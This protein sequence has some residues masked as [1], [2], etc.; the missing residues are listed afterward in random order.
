MQHLVALDG[1]GG[2]HFVE[3]LGGIWD[4]GDAAFVVDPRLPLVA[5]AELFAAIRPTHALDADGSMTSVPD[6]D[7]VEPGDALVIATSGTSGTPK[8]TVLTHAALAAS[9]AATSKRLDISSDDHWL[10]CLPLAHIGGLSVVIR[11]LLTGTRLTVHAGFDAAAVQDSGAT[12]VSLVG[13]ALRRIDPSL[14]RV[15]VLGGSRPPPDRPANSVTTYGMTETGSGVVYDGIPLDGVEVRIDVESEIS[16]RCPM[17]LRCYRD[18][19]DPRTPD[20]WYPTG[21]LGRWL[22]DGRLHVDGR[23]GDVIVTGG[24]KVWPEAVERALAG[25]VGISDLAVAGVPDERWGQAVTAFVVSDSPAAVTLDRLRA[26]V[27]ETMP[28]YAAPQRMEIVDVIPRTSLGKPQRSLL[29]A[30]LDDSS[31]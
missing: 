22:P 12:L 18:G 2:V 11:A 30:A 10:A 7:P 5:R 16:L 4:R 31:D 25:C 26:T 21:D 13:A 24:E 20:G 14:F 15:I 27:K 23:R 19:T 6:G 28:A 29:V 8:G 9:A 3:R 1:I 17:L